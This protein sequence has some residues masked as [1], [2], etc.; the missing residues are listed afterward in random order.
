MRHPTTNSNDALFSTDAMMAVLSEEMFFAEMLHFE[1]CLAAA[2]ESRT[3]IPPGIAKALA[4]LTLDALDLTDLPSKTAL[5]GNACIPF[6]SVLTKSVAAIDPAAAAYVHWGATSQDVIDTAH[7]L[8]WRRALNLIEA[9]LNKLCYHLAQRTR[10]HRNTIM[11]GRTWLQQAPPVTLGYKFATWLDSLHRH[12][13]RLT[14]MKPRVF[15]LQFGGA[16]GTLA[17]YKNEGKALAEEVAARLQLSVPDIPWHTQRDRIG[18]FAA[19]LT[20][21]VGTLGKIGRDVSLLMQSEVGEFSESSDPGRGGSSTMPHKR[22][23]V[24]SAVLLSAATRVPALASTIFTAMIQE[25]ERGLGGWHA[26]WETVPE[27]LRLTAG[28]LRAAITIVEEGSAFSPAMQLNLHLL[29]GVPM[30]EAVSFALGEKMGKPQAHQLI[31]SVSRKALENHIDMLEALQSEPAITRLF[32]LEDLNNLLQ[33]ENY[34]G[35]TNAFI[36]AVLAAQD[37]WSSNANP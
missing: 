36:D 32:S 33:P 35:S 20:L 26:E 30:A 6:V 22:N 18:E 7:V 23:P 19:N 1:A 14:Q 3:L 34:L 5:A 27:I 16:V 12:R 4:S 37:T 21:L 28:A 24:S 29:K 25:H 15:T 17:P 11:P 9:D 10:E 31:E 13:E 8:Q 2:L